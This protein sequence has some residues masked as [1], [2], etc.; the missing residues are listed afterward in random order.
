M[1]TAFSA[2]LRASGLRV[3]EVAELLDCTPATVYNYV[4]GRSTPP[5]DAVRRLAEI[6]DA[7]RAEIARRRERTRE[8]MRKT[9]RRNQAGITTADRREGQ[10]KAV[11]ARLRRRAER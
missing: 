7:E 8:K 10:K 2:A 6:T 4:N 1:S 3:A 9:L 11:T 5:P